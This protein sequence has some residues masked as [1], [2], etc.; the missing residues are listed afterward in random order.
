MSDMSAVNARD[1]IKYGFLLIGYVLG[2]A[3]IGAI[4]MAIGMG[5]FESGSGGLYESSSPGV[6][7]VGGGVA[8]VGA[9]AMYAGLF[10][11]SYKIVADGV[12]R[13]IESAD[14]DL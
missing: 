11:A 3:I 8:L 6:M 1:G 10:G 14:R 5:I 9:V 13:G 12:K 2:V 4:V 7:L